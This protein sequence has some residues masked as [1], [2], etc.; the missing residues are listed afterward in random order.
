MA[1]SGDRHEK[2]KQTQLR[3][4]TSPP[5]VI[6]NSVFGSLKHNFRNMNGPPVT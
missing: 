6:R 2:I 3:E 5:K 1:N 4:S